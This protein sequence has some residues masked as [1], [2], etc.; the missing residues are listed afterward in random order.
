M[1]LHPEHETVR[2]TARRFD[3]PIR[4][5]GLDPQPVGQPVDALPVHGIDRCRRH[6]GPAGQ[7]TAFGQLHRMCRTILHLDRR[8]WVFAMIA[9]A[10]HLV[11]A[12]MQAAAE[13]HVQFLETATDRQHRQIAG[14]RFLQQG[15]RVRIAR[16]IM[17][18][19]RPA[20]RPRI[21]MRLDV[22]Y[23]AGQQQA[24]QPVQPRRGRQRRLQAG[25]QHRGDAGRLDQRADVLFT[26]RREAVM[27]QHRAVGGQADPRGRDHA[28]CSGDLQPR[29]PCA[30][31]PR[32]SAPPRRR[33]PP[34][35]PG[36]DAATDC[37]LL[38]ASVAGILCP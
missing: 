7:P 22:A 34:H 35:T 10:R 14:Q 3:Q 15:E 8:L 24:L 16:R 13:R 9:Q 21:Q 1:P 36:A 17:P 37:P 33:A 28:S 25:Q 26:G 4:G 11:H 12:R 29:Y 5:G 23:R 30:Q 32:N 20:R 27:A 6:P 38:R 2:G 18:I 31:S 19:A